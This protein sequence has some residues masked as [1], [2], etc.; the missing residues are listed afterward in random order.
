[1]HY[2]EGL[3]MLVQRSSVR[4]SGVLFSFNRPS[5]GAFIHLSNLIQ[6]PGVPGSRVAEGQSWEAS[7][8]L[9]VVSYGQV[10]GEISSSVR[11]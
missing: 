3:H 10:N 8:V 2:P 7:P 5:L 4:G 6:A 11:G 9:S 1:M